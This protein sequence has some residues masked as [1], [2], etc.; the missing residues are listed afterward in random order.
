MYKLTEKVIGILRDNQAM[1]LR[2][3][4]GM[5]VGESAVANS[6]KMTKGR[7]IAN[8][9]GAVETLMSELGLAKEDIV[10]EY[11]SKTSL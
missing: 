6:L 10:V 11:E 1:R 4:L 3:A 8:N 9:L 7:S 2:V 5:G